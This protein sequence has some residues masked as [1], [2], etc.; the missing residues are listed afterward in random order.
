MPKKDEQYLHQTNQRLHQSQH[1]LAIQR[2][3]YH[4][5][6]S[7]LHVANNQ[8]KTITSLAKQFRTVEIHLN[9]VLD[10]SNILQDT[11]IQLVDFETIIEPLNSIY[12]EMINSNIMESFGFEI[13]AETANQ[14]KT[15]FRKLT[16]QL[17]KM[18]LIDEQ[19]TSARS[20]DN[21]HVFPIYQQ[22]SKYMVVNHNL[23]DFYNF[24]SQST[25][26]S[27]EIELGMIV[28]HTE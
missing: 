16:V 8:L 14:I 24:T 3:H 2:V 26:T 5:A 4:T 13:S 25:R 27:S 9:N 11:L 18:P 6:Q 21:C 10:S 23:Q 7:N 28:L 1:N 19:D 20:D 22:C 12:H 17:S 15:N